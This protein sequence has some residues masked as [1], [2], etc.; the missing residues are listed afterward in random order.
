[1]LYLLD[2]NVTITAQNKYYPIDQVPEFWEWLLHQ[3][4]AGRVKMPREIL[5]EVRAG[6]KEKDPLLDW[7]KVPGHAKALELPEE[8]DMAL[9]QRAIKKGY[10]AKLDDIQIEGRGKDPFL[11][12]YGLAGHERCVVTVETRKPS[13]QPQNRKLPDACD[14][15]G[16]K[17]IDPFEFNRALG[18]RTS[19]RKPAKN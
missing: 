9:V 5:D 7:L 15:V 16:V 1:M 14:L 2:A 8:P 3:A 19:W 11:V 13:L 4:E 17:C 10:S 12:A 18:F 6:R